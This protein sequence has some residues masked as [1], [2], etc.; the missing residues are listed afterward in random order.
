LPVP[1]RTSD[2]RA[3]GLAQAA[4]HRRG[5]LA[6]RGLVRSH[7]ARTPCEQPT[8]FARYPVAAPGVEGGAAQIVVS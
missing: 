8:A 3:A 6:G 7:A 1:W 4:D 2:R 5:P